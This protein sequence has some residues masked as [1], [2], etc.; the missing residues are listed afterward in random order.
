MFSRNVDQKIHNSVTFLEQDEHELSE[1][2]QLKYKYLKFA[3]KYTIK[4]YEL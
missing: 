3:L 1:N 4:E 2:T